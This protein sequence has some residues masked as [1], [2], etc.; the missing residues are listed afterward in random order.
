[1]QDW[2]VTALLGVVEGVTEFVPV[3][4]TGHL[5]IVEHALGA[6][7]SDLFNVVIQSGAVLA[8]LPVF[9]SR[10]GWIC[11]NWRDGQTRDYVLKLAVAFV[12]TCIGGAALELAGV[13]LPERL[14]PVAIAMF[15]GGVAF[16]LVELWLRTRRLEDKITWPVALGVAAGQL[17]A[18]ACPGVSRSGASILACL[19]LGTARPAATEFSFIVG[20]PTMLAAGA[21]KIFSALTRAEVGATVEPWPTI[22]LGF[23]IAA[24]VSFVAV[25]W[26][27][28][29]VQTH[30]FAVFGWYRIAAAIV[31]V[32]VGAGR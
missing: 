24:V 28:R 6:K 29:Y 1:M 18:A 17:L 11:T 27:V 15:A 2:L 13:E 5:L 26:L 9:K 4:S 19:I 12:L 32:L 22:L 21:L 3:S 30:T 8:V 7:R 25:K 23:G 31:L 14:W 20:V 10:L 16:L